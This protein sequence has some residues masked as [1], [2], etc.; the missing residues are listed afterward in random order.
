MLSQTQ[1]N[2]TKPWISWALGLTNLTRIWSVRHSRTAPTNGLAGWLTQPDPGF[3]QS[4]NTK[5]HQPMD[6]LAV[7]LNLNY[8]SVGLV[9]LCLYDWPY[10]GV[11]QDKRLT[12]PWVGGVLLCLTDHN[13][14]YQGLMSLLEGFSHDKIP[15]FYQL[16]LVCCWRPSCIILVTQIFDGKNLPHHYAKR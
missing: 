14:P 2:S 1:Q 5:A 13:W 9:E 16:L 10:P 8:G 7:C 6:W 12:N 3:S 4:D 11:S 15:I